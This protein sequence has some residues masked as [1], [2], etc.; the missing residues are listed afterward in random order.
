MS[1]PEQSKT[2][3]NLD[4]RD[5]ML[6]ST[7]ELQRAKSIGMVRLIRTV[8]RP[9][10]DTGVI[11]PMTGATATRRQSQSAY[12]LCRVQKQIARVHHTDNDNS[13]SCG[14]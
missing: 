8:A 4:P 14:R 1:E 6:R 3:V 5:Q 12:V 9:Y 13:A 11:S 10:L 7:I 2:L